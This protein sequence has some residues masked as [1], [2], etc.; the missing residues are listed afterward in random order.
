MFDC[1]KFYVKSIMRAMSQLRY[2]N[3]QVDSCLVAGLTIQLLLYNLSLLLN[4]DFIWI[5]GQICHGNGKNMRNLLC[6]F[7]YLKTHEL[8]TKSFE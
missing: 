1:V 8:S 7:G 6:F 4:G 5:L 3:P 2:K